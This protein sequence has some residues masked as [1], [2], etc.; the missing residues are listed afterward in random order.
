MARIEIEGKSDAFARHVLTIS[1]AMNLLIEPQ[2]KFLANAS[3]TFSLSR[4]QA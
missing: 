4:R 2:G 1:P 3:I